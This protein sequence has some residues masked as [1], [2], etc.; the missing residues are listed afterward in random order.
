MKRQRW[1][2]G[3]F[4]VVPRGGG[5]TQ[6]FQHK[7]RMWNS[8]GYAQNFNVLKISNVSQRFIGGPQHDWL[9]V[10]GRRTGWLSPRQWEDTQLFSVGHLYV[11]S[12]LDS[13]VDTEN[14][15]EE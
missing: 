4:E 13:C 14:D 2:F 11:L 8:M 5:Y 1:G 12:H 7:P 6:S 3:R 10:T 9:L 15:F